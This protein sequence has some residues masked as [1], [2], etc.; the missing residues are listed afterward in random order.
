MRKTKWSDY[1]ISFLKENY[2]KKG[3]KYCADKLNL[4][5][6]QIKNK[7][8]KMGLTMLKECKPNGKKPYEKLNIN[9]KKFFDLEDPEVIYFLGLLWSDGFMYQDNNVSHVGITMVED[10][11]ES[12]RDILDRI[13]KWNYYHRKNKNK[14]WKPSINVM[15]NNKTIYNF[16][17]END[18]KYKSTKS[19]KKILNLIPD[20]L[21]HYF[22]LGVVDGDGCFYV[23][24]TKKN[25]IN[26]FTITS[27]YNYEWKSFSDLCDRLEI[28]YKIKRY[29]YE[30][31]SYSILRITN[32]DGIIKLG[33]YIY[34]SS[35]NDI[36]LKRKYES[37]IK[38]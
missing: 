37:F 30:K 22:F 21:K 20:N 19:P 14:T 9:P 38:I 28:K 36:Y 3:F 7:V 1:E 4:T 25:N 12:I 18:F 33:N 6:T 31:K 16:L 10:D 29:K 13:G 32:K 23:R 35:E 34:Q 17:S 2:P 5:N 15:T 11:V 27:S 26:Q 8:F 24:K